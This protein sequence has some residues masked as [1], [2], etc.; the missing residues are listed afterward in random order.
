MNIAAPIGDVPLQQLSIGHVE[1]WHLAMRQRGLSAS[2][3]RAA[4]GL[5]RRALADAVKHQLVARNVA[6]DHGPPAVEPA[7]RV[8]APNADQV[9]ELLAKLAGDR[10]ARSR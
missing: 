10:V 3:T 2:S 5:V 1:R 6:I 4:H 9:R 7:E 8:T